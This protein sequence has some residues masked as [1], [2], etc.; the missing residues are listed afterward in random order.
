MPLTSNSRW[1]AS[2]K[3][4][5]SSLFNTWA[6]PL[7]RVNMNYNLHSLIHNAEYFIHWQHLKYIFQTEKQNCKYLFWKSLDKHKD[8]KV[9]L[10]WYQDSVYY[11]QLLFFTLQV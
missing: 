10:F 9:W 6:T 2:S 7:E 4:F 1:S 8:V 3:G 5:P 11:F